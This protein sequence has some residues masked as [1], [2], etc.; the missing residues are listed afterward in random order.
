MQQGKRK[1][2][3]AKTTMT[4]KQIILTFMNLKFD[5]TILQMIFNVQFHSIVLQLIQCSLS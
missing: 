2:V 3:Y 4:Y 1:Y 5:E